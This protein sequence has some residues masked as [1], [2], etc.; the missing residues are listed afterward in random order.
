MNSATTTSRR[1]GARATF[2]LLL[3]TSMLFS[4]PLLAQSE[5][6]LL[7]KP[8]GKGAY[9]MVY[10]QGEN[11]LYLATSQSRK[12]DKGGVVYRLDPKT[13][14]IT[15]VI[16]ND[17][18]PFGAAIN[19]KTDTLF[20]GNTVNNSVTAI[21]AKTGEV[22]GRLV[23][24]ARQRTETVKPLAPRELVADAAT[25]TLYITGLGESSVVW[26]VDGKDLTLRTTITDTGKYGTGLAL[27]AAAGRLYVT[28]ADGELVTIDTKTNKVLTRKKLD[29]A[30]EHFFLNLSLDP[31]THRAFITDSKQAQVLV[32][33]T[34]DGTV[35]SKIEVPESLAVL[36][37]PARNEVYVTHRK[38][39]EVSV[40]DAKSYK[41]LNTLKT[42]T[43]PNSLALSPDGQTLY[44]SV[45]QASSREKEATAPDDVIRI[46]L[47]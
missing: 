24:D 37:N 2:P 15:Q 8:V 21:D 38:A 9:E 36:F 4:T 34:R 43:H 33:D 3:L 28:N 25:D 26:V 13:L 46:A 12:Q 42:P 16:H 29:E 20:F 7:R 45:K 11:A 10:S 27:D 44:V 22:K 31:A 14:D 40:I 47:K 32:V 39:G 35:L 17:I 18:K 1:F 23:L 5:P 41:L 19:G 6:E 30:K